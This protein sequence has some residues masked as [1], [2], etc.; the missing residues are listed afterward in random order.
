MLPDI[1]QEDYWYR[2][3]KFEL[4]RKD[5]AA[6]EGELKGFHENFADCFQCSES[7][8]NWESGHL[9]TM[10]LFRNALQESSFL[11][12]KKKADRS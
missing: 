3:E 6:F 9:F 1:R 10:N 5:I 8:D 12:E 4:E 7:R 2:V 11:K